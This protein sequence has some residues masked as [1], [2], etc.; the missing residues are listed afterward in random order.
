MNRQLVENILGVIKTST[1]KAVIVKG[2]TKLRTDVVKDKNGII[3][4]REAG[5]VPPMVRFLSKPHEK[6]LEVALSIMGNCCTDEQ[7]CREA[8]ENK[9]AIPL[10]TILKSIPNPVIQCRACRLLGN[11]AK[12]DTNQLLSTH[13]PAIA[14]ALCRI[15]EDT[16]DVQTRMMAFR[17][18]RFLLANPQFLKH[19]LQ[20]SGF[21]ILLRILTAIMKNESNT[22]SEEKLLCDAQAPLK[23]GLKRNQHRE[24]YFEEV[25]RNLEG[26]RSDIFDHEVLKNSTRNSNAYIIPQEQAALDLVCEILKCLLVI[27]ELQI[28]SLV[29]ESLNRAHCTLAPIVHFITDEKKSKHRSAAL[30]ILSN[31]S[32]NQGAFYILSS[33]DAILAACEVLVADEDLSESERR[34]C[35]HIIS[36]LSTD[37]CNRSKIRRSG[38]LRKFIVMIKDTVSPAEKASIL[39]VLINFQYDN[40]SMDL[41]LREGLVL[42]LVKELN[43]YMVSDEDYYKKKREEKLQSESKKRKLPELIKESKCKFAKV[44][45]EN[46]LDSDSPSS[47]PR[48]YNMPSSPCSSRSM[49]PV[50]GGHMYQPNNADS[51][52]ESYSPVCSDEEDDEEETEAR[53]I[54]SHL[55]NNPNANSNDHT[56]IMNLLDLAAR[57]EEDSILIEDEEEVS[58]DV[59]AIKL[60]Q[61]GHLPHNT[62]DVI[63]NLLFRVTCLVK[64]SL[65]LGKPETMNTLIKAINMFGLNTDFAG[66]LTNILLESQFFGNVIKQGI[67]HQLYQLT[68]VKE[69]SKDG[70]GFLE[71]LTSVSECNYGKEELARL[72]RSDDVLSQ[73]RAA[74]TVGY[75][76]RSKPLLYQFLN[77]GNA[78]T[79]LLGIILSSKEDEFTAEAVD[80][81][82]C[83]SRYTLGIHVPQLDMEKRLDEYEE[84]VENAGQSL[85]EEDCD[86]RFVVHA[87][88]NNHNTSKEPDN[89]P[90]NITDDNDTEKITA[91][92][93][94]KAMLC[95]ISEVFNTML[96][97]D[98]R[99][100]KEGEIHL[101]NYSVSGLR[102]FLNLIV[103]QSRKQKYNIPPANQYYALLEAFEMSRIYIIPEMEQFVLEL[104]IALLDETNCL[105]VLE[106][107]MKNYH[108][109]LTEMAINYYLCSTLS[110]E[111]KVN[112]FRTADYSTYSTEW[113]Q[114]IMEAILA[115]CRNGF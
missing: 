7:S 30:K 65:D 79:L 108:V 20:S 10:A 105:N 31:L 68:K 21:T 17:S 78:L 69:T 107:S 40:M 19:F 62:I 100:G 63:D 96:N 84:F 73:K 1:D 93:F 66:T 52:E 110:T 111:A 11:L 113:F 86:M 56:I 97:S 85:Q 82:T 53:D 5:G 42:V 26:V 80:A 28:N 112:L 101:R 109:E 22:E 46:Y 91:V 43:M 16:S 89:A 74:I 95:S 104:L 32:K 25:A 27:S 9:I 3:L 37:A 34:H 41:M 12:V 99:E 71:T 51:D 48:S 98:F 103:R 35:I 77:D 13:C 60:P 76:I 83:M 115:R 8:L 33:A 90:N 87:P 23:V 2:L 59:P 54:S 72:L 45:E 102:Y 6:I 55:Y 4:F 38:A 24:K 15:I 81:L 70:F 58:Q 64:K 75:L 44:R 36:I 94:S 18:C 14:Q 50:G 106:W 47:S 67:S 88:N 57:S 61:L 49:S 29:W 92:A 114:M 39:N